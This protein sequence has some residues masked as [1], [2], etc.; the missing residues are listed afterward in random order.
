MIIAIFLVGAF[1]SIVSFLAGAFIMALLLTS[2][3]G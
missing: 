2:E 1:T 3:E